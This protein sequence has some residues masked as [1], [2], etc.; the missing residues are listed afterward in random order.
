MLRGLLQTLLLAVLIVPLGL[1]GGLL[2]S[3]ITSSHIRVLRFLGMAY[4][5]FFR[6]FPPLML[7][8]LVFSGLPF[9]GI[10][11]DATLA[12]CFAFLLHASS[13]YGEIFRAG[14]ESVPK[15]HSEAARS[16]G[17]SWRQTMVYVVLPQGVRNVLPE[18]VSNTIELIKL[19]T[20][21][22]V[23]SAPEL[24]HSADLARS[25][26]YNTSPLMLAAIL[27]LL[28]LWPAVLLSRR[29]DNKI[30]SLSR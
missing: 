2:V 16:T 23:I 17:L 25:L 11:L 26:T 24:L 3:F 21:A 27:Y 30:Q 28:L 13:Y 12:I 20:L 5:D 6:A 29:L 15:G 9:I 18:L 7:L 10:R 8:I 14:I 22:S 4:V 1:C 19:T